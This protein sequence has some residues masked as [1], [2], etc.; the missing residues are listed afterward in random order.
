MVFHSPKI[1]VVSYFSP[2]NSYFI[3]NLR[4]RMFYNSTPTSANLYL[5]PKMTVFFLYPD[6]ESFL[7]LTRQCFFY[8]YLNNN[9]LNNSFF[10]SSRTT[11]TQKMHIY[12]SYF[13]SS[14]LSLVGL[15]KYKHKPAIKKQTPT[16]EQSTIQLFESQKNSTL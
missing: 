2:Y 10:S 9:T 5:S 12:S 15:R 3:F 13:F 6:N 1:S 4:K 7:L 11:I 14:E 8:F 16:T